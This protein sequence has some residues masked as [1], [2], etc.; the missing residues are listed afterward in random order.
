MVE[1]ESVDMRILQNLE[2]VVAVLK[3]TLALA[4]RLEAVGDGIVERQVL[5]IVHLEV[6]AA[7]LNVVDNRLYVGLLAVA[8][9]EIERQQGDVVFGLGVVVEQRAAPVLQ[10][11]GLPD[12]V[13][14]FIGIG[15]MAAA[16]QQ[17]CVEAMSL[18]KN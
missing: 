7:L 12:V 10:N 8:V 14:Q 6:L 15:D 17:N 4:S 18:R 16:L 3:G 2:V 5:R 13:K 1:A 9:V 11:V